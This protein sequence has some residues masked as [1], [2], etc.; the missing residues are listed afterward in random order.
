MK[1]IID[2]KKCL[3]HKLSLQEVMIAVALSEAKSYTDV[4][5]NLILRKVLVFENNKYHITPEWKNTID[6]IIRESAGAVEKTDEELTQLATKIQECFPKQKMRDRYGRETNFY[7][8]CNK[9]E[10]KGSLKRFF[11]NS[12]FRNASDEEIIDATKRYVASFK[13]DYSGKMRLAK[14]FVWKNEVKPK[15]DGTGYVEPLSDLE[16]FLENKEEEGTVVTNSDDWLMS[17]R[18]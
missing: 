12:D 15:G 3:K 17:A 8:R 11:E 6:A 1:Y 5:E 18:N 16:T 10:I 9:T 4:L 13:G 7:Y 14:Y 2:E